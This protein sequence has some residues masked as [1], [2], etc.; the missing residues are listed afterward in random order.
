ME[1]QLSAHATSTATHDP[2]LDLLKKSLTAAVYPESSWQ[3]VTGARTGKSTIGSRVRQWIL[4]RLRKRGLLLVRWKPF[5]IASRNRGEDWP[6]FGYSMVGLAR[7]DNIQMCVETVLREG[8]PGDLIETGVWRGGSTIL[9]KAIL[10]LHAIADRT[11]WVADSFAGLPP[12]TNDIDRE[13]ASYDLAGLSYLAVSQQEVSENFARFGLLDDRVR[14]L[15]GWFSDT[16]PTAPIETLS[17]LRLDGDMYES[18]MDAL[19]PLY[20]KVSVGGF[21]I[22]DDYNSWPGCKRAIDEYRETHRITDPLVSIDGHAVWWRVTRPLPT[23]GG[24]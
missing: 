1:S 16:L 11:V 7:M 18:T 8:V 19:K 15:K 20:P 13:Q 17:V 3:I 2:Y 10:S 24:I 4:N 14:F 6:C 22:V 12:P 9:M 5:E 23:A 21:V